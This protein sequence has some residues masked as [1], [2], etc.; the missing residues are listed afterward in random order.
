MGTY[1]TFFF[2]A[3][4]IFSDEFT[5]QLYTAFRGISNMKA[6]LL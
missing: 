4:S 2:L 5:L 1:Q 6:T 3:D